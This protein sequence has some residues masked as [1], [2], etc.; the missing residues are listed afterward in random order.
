MT[1]LRA[2][3]LADSYADLRVTGRADINGTSA[4][5]VTGTRAG[6]THR[7]FFSDTTGLLVRRTDDI[8][9]PLG[10]VPEQYDFTEF[11]QIDGVTVP[12]RIVWSRADYQVTFAVGEV[13][14]TM[15]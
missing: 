12:M 14:H 13:R 1:F 8:D 7:L 2:L 5:E 4:V 9:T 11:R 10:L 6:L 15:R 3:S